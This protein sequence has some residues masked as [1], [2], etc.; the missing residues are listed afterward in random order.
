[1]RKANQANM[2]MMSVLVWG[3]YACTPE[4]AVPPS[5]SPSLSAT[6]AP[7]PTEAIVSP[8]ITPT[9]VPAPDVNNIYIGR[10]ETRQSIALTEAMVPIV[11]I[12]SLDNYSGSYIDVFL[13]GLSVNDS[14][15]L[16][17]GEMLEH[18]IMMLDA[19]QEAGFVGQTIYS[20]FRSFED[21][22]F[23]IGR[24]ESDYPQDTEIFLAEA[25]RSEHQLG[26]VIDLGWGA[27][28]L[29]PYITYNN[30]AAGGFYHWLKAHAHEYGFVLSYPF[31][32]N[33]E[34][35]MSNLFEPWV[36]EYIAETWHIRY[37]GLEFATHIFGFVDDQG[38]NYLDPYSTIIPQQFYLPRG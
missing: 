1:M 11:D 5:P 12:T 16:G 20:S 30:E 35:T 37:V 13:R 3:L 17:G 22:Q 9:S 23:L 19:A 28:L 8:T 6:A 24:G 18:L 29:N 32:T 33:S 36:T 15:I 26:T 34:G 14:P 25:G 31:K 7:R 38:R 2:I 21:Q 27:S 4:Q 10:D